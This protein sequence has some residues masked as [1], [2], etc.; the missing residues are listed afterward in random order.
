MGLETRMMFVISTTNRM[1]AVSNDEY[2]T[3]LTQK[4]DYYYKLVDWDAEINMRMNVLK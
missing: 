3:N 1:K 4:N 2:I